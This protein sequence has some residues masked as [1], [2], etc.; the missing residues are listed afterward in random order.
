[1]ALT[2]V[3]SK[4]FF[5]LVGTKNIA[6]ATDFDF[7]INKET[8]DV[9][10]LDPDGW[11]AYLVDLKSWKISC[12][13]LVTRGT[14]GGTETNNDD[15]LTSLLGT[16]TALTMAVNTKVSGDKYI[17]G[18]AFL[19]SCKESGKVG[20]KVTFSCEFTGSGALTFPTNP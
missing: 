19:T 5:V 6:F 15:L 20:D 12:S 10:T 18:S 2:A 11:K 3:L 1:M 13:G 8:I 16:D 14:P 9:T 17:T 7:E 4:E